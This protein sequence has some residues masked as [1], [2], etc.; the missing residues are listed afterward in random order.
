M[1]TFFFE[2]LTATLWPKYCTRGNR[3]PREANRLLRRSGEFWQREYYD[4]LVR[5][6]KEFYRIVN[7]IAENPKR[8]GRM[9]ALQ[10]KRRLLRTSNAGKKERK[11]QQNLRQE[12]LNA[13]GQLLH[14]VAFT[15]HRIS[16]NPS[17][18]ERS[19]DRIG[20]HGE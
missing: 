17:A 14:A 19:R 8:D 7:Y 20:V 13:V 15:D 10:G 3:F 18:W 1:F 5:S 12:G 9:P 4:H 2:F 11:T 16:G 6:E